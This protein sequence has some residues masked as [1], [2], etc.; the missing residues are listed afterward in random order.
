MSDLDVVGFGIIAVCYFGALISFRMLSP[1]IK[2]V[3]KE[4]KP[5]DAPRQNSAQRVVYKL[6][7]SH[8]DSAPMSKS[9][10]LLSE[11]RGFFNLASI[12]MGFFVASHNVRY[13]LRH[14]TLIGLTSLINLFERFEVFFY[15][16]GLIAFS[17]LA[18]VLQKFFINCKVPFATQRIIHAIYLLTLFVGTVAVIM[19]HSWPIVPKAS[20]LAELIVILMKIHSY[21]VNNRHFMVE[22]AR[23][24]GSTTDVSLFPQNVTFGNFSDFL[25][26]PSLVYELSYPRTEKIR[27]NYLLEKILTGVGIFTVI[28]VIVDIYVS[29]VLIKSPSESTIEVVAELIIP[30]TVSYMLVFY[31]VFDCICNGFAE[32]TKF[33]DRLFYD[34]WWN[35]TTMDEFA[36]NWNRPVH[37]WLMRHIYLET[38]ETFKLNRMS[39]VW[40]TFLFSS[41]LHEAFM[42]VCF[43][44]FR[45]WLFVSQMAQIPMIIIGRD[46][47]GTR[48]G[49]FLFWFGIVLGVPLLSVLYCREYYLTG[50]MSK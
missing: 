14:G 50:S 20:L 8:L 9:P 17:F 25:L 44:M 7:T 16:G 39:A 10:M 41:M 32:L 26:I 1:P 4:V 21:L 42:V 49:N 2:P 38:M 3:V 6:R 23:K 15:W 34:D 18:V 30:F 46:L 5:D 48:I 47:K 45:P 35:S 33:G 29:P 27:W 12:A 43:K 28:H 22:K 36:R 13:W 31:M 40:V 11:F 37:L 19:L 24:E